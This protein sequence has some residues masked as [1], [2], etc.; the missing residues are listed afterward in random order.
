MTASAR[1]G[2]PGYPRLGALRRPRVSLFAALCLVSGWLHV[3]QHHSAHEAPAPGRAHAAL[4]HALA[5]EHGGDCVHDEPR[6]AHGDGHFDSE[7]SDL[8][9]LAD[10]P[11]VDLPRPPDAAPAPSVARAG[12]PPDGGA[13]ARP[14]TAPPIRGPPS[15]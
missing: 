10:N 4:A 9:E 12:P 8:C 14:A 2:H 11:W 5:H 6:P 13:V 15:A 1:I 7:T 3:W